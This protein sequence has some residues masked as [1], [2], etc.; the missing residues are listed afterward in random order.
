MSHAG[1][2]ARPQRE[3]GCLSAVWA[4]GARSDRI[5]RARFRQRKGGREG[6]GASRQRSSGVV[7]RGLG[8]SAA[9]RF[10]GP[11]PNHPP[12]PAAYSIAGCC[13]RIPARCLPARRLAGREGR[14]P[15]RAFLFNRRAGVDGQ[16]EP[17][18]GALVQHRDE[19]QFDRPWPDSERGPKPIS[20]LSDGRFILNQ[21]ASDRRHQIRILRDGYA[22]A[23]ALAD[24][25]SD[26]AEFK[27]ERINQREPGSGGAGPPRRCDQMRVILPGHEI[28]ICGQPAGSGLGRGR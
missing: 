24:S 12:Q 27:L 10:P 25:K 18:S 20:T 3:G 4:G 26:P 16:G 21:L 15:T 1:L 7:E 22:P 6:L 2:P 8:N 14:N 19:F 5:G 13:C 17:V 23:V 11:L 28:P 9:N